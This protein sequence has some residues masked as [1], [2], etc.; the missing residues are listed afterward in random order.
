MHTFLQDLRY[1]VRQLRKSPV[2]TITAVLTFAIGIGV[3]TASFSIMD[4][5]VLR[6]LG[7]P[8][9]NHVVVIHEQQNHGNDQSAALANFV[10]WQRQSRSFE[11]LAIQRP[12]DMSLTGA[13][14]A[15]HVQ[16]VYTTPSFF[17]ILRAQPL[18]GRIL[19]AGDTQPGKEREAVLS[20]AFWKSHFDADPKAVGRKVELDS[21]AYTIIGVMPKTLQ[22]PSVADL[23]LP[24]APDAASLANR[25][26]HEYKVLGR[27]APGVSPGQAQAE[28]NVIAGQLAHTYP[29]TN[30]AW[31]VK[32]QPLLADINGTLTPLYFSLAQGAT[33]FVLLVVCANIANLQFARGLA[34]R[35]EIALRTALGASRKRVLR[36]LLTENILLGLIGGA[37]GLAF[38]AFDMRITKL[39]M[40][41]RVARLLAGWSN[42]SLNPRALVFSFLLAVSAGILS[43]LAPALQSLRVNL[44][45]QLKSGSRSLAGSYRGRKLRNALASA[46]ISL[47]V[48]LLIGATLMGKGMLSMLHMADQYRPEQTLLFNVHLPEGH[49]DTADKQAA[50]YNQSL[51]RLRALP[52]VDHA[53]IASALPSSDDGWLNEVQIENHP[54]IPGKQS[55][56]LRMTVSSGYFHA[57]HIPL[58]SRM[59]GGRLFSSGDDLQATPFAVVSREFVTQFFPQESPIGHRIRLTAGGS[60]QTPWIQIVGVVEEVNYSMWEKSN[61]ARG[62]P[63]RR[64]VPE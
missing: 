60:H 40:P 39:L 27:L 3:N 41:E 16:A 1:A 53:E 58:A 7:V 32:V 37:G 29:A 38:A 14:D 30:Q 62:L 57:F 64:A 44:V 12:A 63:Q 54:V 33:F 49:Y 28:M 31:S 61:P 46:Q 25:S 55:S 17:S 45:E 23:F 22:Y 51:E 24:F 35:P 56:A 52:G 59:P 15:A 26:A 47:A 13:G 8:G 4:A 50:W 20:Y 6:P 21:R 36:Q 43:G 9:L 11:E 5:V 34:R 2:F 48:A 42:I 19:D 10:D 18:S